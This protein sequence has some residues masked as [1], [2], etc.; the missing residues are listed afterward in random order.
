[1]KTSRTFHLPALRR[2]A[3]VLLVWCALGSSAAAYQFEPQKVIN[4]D[5]VRVL[6]VKAAD[7]D[8]DGDPDALFG[9]QNDHTLAWCENT[10][11]A[12]GFSPLNIITDDG[13]VATATAARDVDLDG[14]VDV[15]VVWMK[16]ES[17][18]AWHENVD[19]LGSFPV[20]HVI[21]DYGFDGGGIELYVE[22]LDADGDPDVASTSGITATEGDVLWSANVDGFGGAWSTQVVS[23]DVQ[24]GRSV[25]AGDLDGDGDPDLISASLIDDKVAW[26][27]NTDGSGSFG[28]QQVMS[29]SINGA[30]GVHAA[31]LDG[32]LDLDVAYVAFVGDEVG[33]FENTDGAGDFGVQHVISAAVNGAKSVFAA[34]LDQDGDNDLVLGNDHADN[35]LWFESA[36]GAGAFLDPKTITTNIDG[37]SEVV[38]VDFDG[39]GNTDV[40]SGSHQ[41]CKVAWYRNTGCPDALPSEETFRL[42]NP[43]NPEALLPGLTS[44]PVIGATWDPVIDHATF[45]PSAVVDFLAIGFAPTDIP[46]PIGTV[47]CGLSPALVVTSAAPGVP[48][49]LPIPADC[50]HVGKTLYTQGGSFDFPSGIALANALDITIGAF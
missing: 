29:T 46:T 19:G 25:Y 40:L 39:D 32:D 18:I 33:W 21:H 34:D 5:L 7:L 17:R 43:P 1:M 12:G 49:A 23:T 2:R 50:V 31:D 22:D 11:G 27:E 35:I 45:K 41:D 6:C 3:T 37:T 28:A 47:L 16:D 4:D 30:F 9:S 26:Y 10:D 14:D 48:F 36:D 20:E 13:N 15:L 44:G 42:G 24:Q 38:P 8:G